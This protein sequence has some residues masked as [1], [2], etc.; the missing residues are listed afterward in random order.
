MNMGNIIDTSSFKKVSNP[1]DYEKF[2]HYPRY[3]CENGVCRMANDHPDLYGWYDGPL[4]Y[5]YRLHDN[6]Q[7]DVMMFIETQE[8]NEKLYIEQWLIAHTAKEIMDKMEKNEIPMRVGVQ[9]S[10]PHVHLLTYKCDRATKTKEIDVVEI[11]VSSLNEKWLPA[12]D[13]MLF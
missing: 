3:P 10:H 9:G 2:L 7:D 13:V 12:P 6:P 1:L 5:R 8:L 11:P 4:F